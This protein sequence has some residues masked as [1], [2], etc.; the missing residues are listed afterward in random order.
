M[1]ISVSPVY[2]PFI[3]VY[4]EPVNRQIARSVTICGMTEK[5]LPVIRPN[6]GAQANY[7]R[8]LTTLIDEMNES[9]RYWL[10]ASYRA[11]E[12]EMAADASPAIE[13]RNALNKLRRR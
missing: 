9:I 4:N 12:P 13:L 8:K 11:N 3:Y 10:R 7:D 1:N 2:A 5:Y 6:A